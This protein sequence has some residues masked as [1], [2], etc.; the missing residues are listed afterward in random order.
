MKSNVENV[1]GSDGHIKAGNRYYIVI[2]PTNKY[3]P[4]EGLIKMEYETFTRVYR[5][6]DGFNYIKLKVPNGIENGHG[7]HVTVFDTDAKP[8]PSGRID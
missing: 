6:E 3:A 4:K 8:S 7:V 2:C 5:G 1:N